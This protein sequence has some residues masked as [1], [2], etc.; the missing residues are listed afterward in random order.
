M[1]TFS[2]LNQVFNVICVLINVIINK[3]KDKPCFYLKVCR[4]RVEGAWRTGVFRTTELSDSSFFLSHLLVRTDLPSFKWLL[5]AWITH[6]F[7]YIKSK[8]PVTLYRR[9]LKIDR[10]SASH[11]VSRS[12]THDLKPKHYSAT[13][14]HI[15]SKKK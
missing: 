3:K 9:T 13:F 8:L 11:T 14:G 15:G 12:M 1:H 2:H 5:Q 4:N 10:V 6:T 7:I